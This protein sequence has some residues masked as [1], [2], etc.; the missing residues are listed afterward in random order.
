MIGLEHFVGNHSLPISSTVFAQLVDTAGP[1]LLTIDHLNITAN[2]AVP[3][4]IFFNLQNLT[5]L[6]FARSPQIIISLPSNPP[7]NLPTWVDYMFIPARN[8]CV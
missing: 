5:R 1:T 4:S 3:K 7:L 6:D 2:H 8:G